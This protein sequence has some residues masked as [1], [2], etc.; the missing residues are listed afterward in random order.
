MQLEGLTE[1]TERTSC[2]TQ[3]PK[4]RL[5]T[6]SD[7]RKIDDLHLH[8]DITSVQIL[9]DHTYNFSLFWTN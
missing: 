4:P 8:S 6:P 2:L 7:V 1:M 3:V 5:M 9:L